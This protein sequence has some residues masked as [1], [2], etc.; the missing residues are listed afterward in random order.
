MA[1]GVHSN[2]CQQC[3]TPET[4]MERMIRLNVAYDFGGSR[5]YGDTVG[6]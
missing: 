1:T 5:R 4:L 6:F 3:L 2:D